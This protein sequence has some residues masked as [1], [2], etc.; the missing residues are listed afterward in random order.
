MQYHIVE[1][2]LYSVIYVIMKLSRPPY[3][4]PL[5]A[6]LD[7]DIIE[8]HVFDK[9]FFWPGLHSVNLTHYTEFCVFIRKSD[10]R[11]PYYNT[12]FSLT[13]GSYRPNWRLIISF[14][15]LLYQND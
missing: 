14:H 15:M 8:Q 9:F 13:N 4:S 6:T 7:V 1:Y 2:I 10:I 5:Q 12:P 11:Y 3:R